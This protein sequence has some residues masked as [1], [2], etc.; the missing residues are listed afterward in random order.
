KKHKKIGM[1]PGS[2]IYTG[3]KLDE[4]IVIELFSYNDSNTS[5][6]R[7][8]KIEDVKLKKEC[9]NWLNI[10]GVHNTDIVKKI[11]DIFK[12]DNLILEDITNINQRAKLEDRDKF[13]YIVLRMF[14]LEGENNKIVSEQLSLIVTEDYLIT[15]QEEPG[16]VFDNIRHRISEGLGKVRKKKADYLAYLILDAVIDNYFNILEKIEYDMDELEDKLMNASNKDDLKAIMKLKKEFIAIKRSISPVR[17]LTTKMFYNRDLEIFKGDMSNYIN[18]LHDH[19]IVIH[20]IMENLSARVVGLVEIYHSSVNSVMNETMRFLTIVSTIFVP[21]TFLA[22]I[23][24]M[25]FENIPELNWEFGYFYLLGI[26]F[27]TA[28]IMFYHF[29]KKKWF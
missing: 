28:C 15:F 17:E 21:L 2:V 27:V 7:F 23:Y 26:M 12:I 29:K 25:N 13:L 24:G 4:K 9:V 14:R 18:D 11:G 22:G 16:D 10:D 5:K 3:N 19:V 1:E 6:E 20:E 8:Q